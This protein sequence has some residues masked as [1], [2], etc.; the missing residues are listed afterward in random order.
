MHPYLS[1][2]LARERIRDWRGRADRARQARRALA[3]RARPA[4]TPARP[5]TV[6]QR[7]TERVALTRCG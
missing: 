5:V 4:G 7:V 6:P 1:Q 3:A 2:E